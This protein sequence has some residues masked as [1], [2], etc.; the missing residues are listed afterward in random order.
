[1]LVDQPF[2]KE[3]KEQ[4]GREIRLGVCLELTQACGVRLR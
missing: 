2:S 3:V 4:E 1:M